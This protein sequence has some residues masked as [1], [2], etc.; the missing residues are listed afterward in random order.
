MMI[1]FGAF[2][3]E[4]RQSM[5][6]RNSTAGTIAGHHPS[7]WVFLHSL[8]CKMGLICN[9]KLARQLVGITAPQWRGPPPNANPVFGN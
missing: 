7:N 2:G 3:T 4:C 1:N 9:W 6:C 8:R 5:P